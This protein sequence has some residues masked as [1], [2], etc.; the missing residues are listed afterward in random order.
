MARIFLILQKYMF[1]GY[2]KWLQIR[3]FVCHESSDGRDEENIK[4]T[5]ERTMCTVK[6]I[7]AKNV[8]KWVKHGLGHCEND[9]RWGGNTSFFR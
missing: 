3:M 4:F 9:S 6:H 8:Y 7:L 2:S 1:S 5:D